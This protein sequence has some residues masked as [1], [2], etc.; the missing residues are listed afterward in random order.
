MKYTLIVAILSL[1]AAPISQA[2]LAGTLNQVVSPVRPIIDRTS[3]DLKAIR[4]EARRKAQSSIEGTRDLSTVASGVLS[5]IP[6]PQFIAPAAT[7]ILS[8][9]GQVV[10]NEVAVES[11]FLAVEK[12]W[13]FLGEE[14]DKVHF[15]GANIEIQKAQF[16]PALSQWLFKVKVTGDEDDVSSIRN[17]LPHNLQ[18]QIG[19]NH[20]YLSQTKPTSNGSFQE[21]SSEKLETCPTP[22]RIGMVDTH[23]A[24][25]HPLLSHVNLTQA[26][27][28]VGHNQDRNQEQDG[29]AGS[30]TDVA[31]SSDHGTAVASLLAAS[32]PKSSQVFN[33]SVFYSRNSVSQ[34]ATLMSLIEGLNYLA[35]QQ[36]DAINMSLAGPDNP[37]LARVINQLDKSGIQIIAAVGNEG[38][39]SLPLYP[40][41]YTETLGITAVDKSNVIYRWANQGDYVDFAAFGVSVNAAHPNGKT[42]RQTGTSMAS[43]RATALYACFLREKQE[44]NAALLKLQQL[45]L[46]AGAPGRDSVFGF[47]VLP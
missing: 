41:A 43:P 23:V 38:P 15:Q 20:I 24:S 30:E 46:D 26:S 34:G 37:I 31:F 8:T 32:L 45:A 7:T 18:S 39:A 9:S 33:A 12:E 28:I 11:G 21:I 19:R 16:L 22:L 13:L 3:S 44:R 36:V 1:I 25:N 4:E 47:G 35:S 2:Q 17:S 5:D 10:V 29:N 42:I 6:A 14:A 27:F 40:A